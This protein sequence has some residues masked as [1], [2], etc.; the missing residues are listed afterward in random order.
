MMPSAARSRSAFA[1][2]IAAFLPPISA[3]QGRG[4]RPAPNARTMP[5]P[6]SYDPVKV[7][8]ATSREAAS[9]API[10]SPPPLT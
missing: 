5:I 6:T 2:T 8:P 10:S 7:M 3:M 9:A 1:L 4:Q